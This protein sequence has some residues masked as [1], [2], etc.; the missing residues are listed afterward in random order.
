M[1]FGDGSGVTPFRSEKIAV[2]GEGDT[3]KDDRGK[4]R[5]DRKPSAKA[6]VITATEGDKEGLNRPISRKNK[7]QGGEGE[8]D[9]GLGQNNTLEKTDGGKLRGADG[10]FLTSS[11][12]E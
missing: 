6:T 3:E 8:W 12:G 11:G 4:E 2:S 10:P 1:D 5:V 9:K 7:Q